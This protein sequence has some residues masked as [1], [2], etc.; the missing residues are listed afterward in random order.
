MKG[1][2]FKKTAAFILALC[3]I[4]VGLTQDFDGKSLSKP[5]II[6]NA[7][8]S[9]KTVSGSVK[10]SDFEDGSFVFLDGNT[11]LYMDVTKELECINEIN[12]A[13]DNDYTLTIEGPEHL[14][15]S[16]IGVSV[17]NMKG[18]IN[19]KNVYASEMNVY[20]GRTEI[21]DLRV[22]NVLDIYGGYF[23]SR[24]YTGS[25]TG[26]YGGNINFGNGKGDGGVILSQESLVSKDGKY[27]DPLFTN[28]PW[29][30]NAN[31]Y[32]L[33]P[34]KLKT[35]S[36]ISTEEISETD[37]LAAGWYANKTKKTYLLDGDDN[38]PDYISIHS[39]ISG[40]IKIK[41]SSLSPNMTAECELEFPKA[42]LGT[43]QMSFNIPNETLNITWQISDDN[44][45]WTDVK[46]S[47]GSD[48][49]LKC[50]IRTEDLNKY[51]R[52]VAKGD[53]YEGSLISPS[54]FVQKRVNN[55]TP[56][57]PRFEYNSANKK[58]Y[59]TNANKNQ[60][61]IILPTLKAVSALTD[62][63]WEKAVS[64]DKDGSFEIN[65]ASGKTNYVYTRFKENDKYCAGVNVAVAKYYHGTASYLSNIE[66]SATT[67]GLN[68]TRSNGSYDV[69]M[70][71]VAE[72]DVSP[73]PA[74][75]TD[76]N[77]IL[78]SKW[79]INNHNTI[80]SA[81]EFGKLYE[82]E[83]CTKPIIASKSYKKVYFKP[84]KQANDVN[85]TAEYTL[86]Q[87]SVV[88]D[89]IKLNISDKNGNFLL[90][91]LDVIYV[92]VM[93]GEKKEGITPNILPVNAAISNVTFKS[94]DKNAPVVEF[95]P[96]KYAVSVD[97]SNSPAGKYHYGVYQNDKQISG[98]VH[99]EVKD[100][101]AC[102]KG[103][104]N[105]DGTLNI[106]DAVLLQRWLLGYPEAT[107]PYWQNADMNDSGAVDTFDYVLA[108]REIL[109]AIG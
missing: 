101:F 6:A 22:D 69:P 70:F 72:I 76:F 79:L 78:G 13:D 31:A 50:N 109:K 90:S 66:L 26:L 3:A 87:N 55:N 23:Y 19:A 84:S 75:A 82:D 20:R 48:D 12:Y 97:A 59:I 108:K 86:G 74:D 47:A 43:T 14:K 10:A 52:V 57:Y 33:Y 77:G 61:Y 73:M 8:S 85:I 5:N 30:I 11:T 25:Y 21:Q 95:D 58:M 16:N 2:F 27:K 4:S 34:Q 41:N 51:I 35:K 44:V 40:K 107:L 56:V 83:E 38:V 32:L 89:T 98:G 29:S 80:D 54:M 53:G 17:I 92:D 24:Y 49:M 91:Y 67:A 60:E 65:G 7:D 36:T 93:S 68:F 9:N 28:V 104:V 103:D 94:S 96:V 88:N 100:P 15:C 64:P 71:C 81:S 105:F 45:S 18:W 62:S 102:I 106:S 99:V 46:I 1:S 37:L 42:V 63:D 39:K